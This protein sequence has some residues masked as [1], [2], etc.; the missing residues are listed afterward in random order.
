MNTP[1]I[2]WAAGLFF[3]AFCRPMSAEIIE[4]VVATVEDEII[5]RTDLLAEAQAAIMGL[6]ESASSQQE[7]DHQ[8]QELLNETLQIQ[9]ENKL[10]MKQALL[11]GAVVTDE[12]VEDSVTALREELYPEFT[13]DEF[14]RE[15]E[16]EGSTIDDLREQRRQYFLAI[17]MR[18]TKMREFRDDV[19]LSESEVSQYYE[20]HKSDYERPAE[21]MISQIQLRASQ[22]PGERART[23][24]RLDAIRE[25][26]LAGADFA[27]LAKSYSQDM[28][29]ENGG[30]MGWHQRQRLLLE[31]IEEAVF[32]LPVGGLTAVIDTRVGVH[33]LRVDDRRDAGLRTLNDVRAEIERGLAEEAARGRY[34]VWMADLHSRGG[35]RIFSR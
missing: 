18:N 30:S 24:A 33:L 31:E 7:F 23:R 11:Y 29:A 26:L 15:L 28:F 35:V 16:R 32:A 17:R 2:V 25:E 22:D 1:R 21:V 3:A 14:L 5:L 20:D 10:L 4:A 34:S 8:V 27:Q 12:E 19:I 9:I 13:Y 6:R